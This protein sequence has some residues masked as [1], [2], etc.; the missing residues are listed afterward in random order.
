[1]IA[2]GKSWTFVSAALGRDLSSV[3]LHAGWLGRAAPKK[4]TAHRDRAEGE[5]MTATDDVRELEEGMA[6]LEAAARKLPMGRGR[7][8]LLQDVARFRTRLAALQATLPKP[9][10]RPKA[11]GK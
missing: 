8:E 2:A 7:D 10:E 5:E 1:L 11:K 6:K 3:K 4:A 9:G